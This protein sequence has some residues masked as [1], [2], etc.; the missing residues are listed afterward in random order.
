MVLDG[1]IRELDRIGNNAANEANDFSRRR[2]GNAVI[3]ARRDLSEDCGRWYPPVLHD[4]HRFFIAISR[5]LVNH[6][7]SD[8]TALDPFVWSAGALSKRRRLVHAVR[9]WAMLPRPPAIWDSEWINVPASAVSADDTAPVFWSN[10]WLFVR[11]PALGCWWFGSR[12]WWHLL[13]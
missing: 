3:D 11:C 6:G 4:L 9:D 12:S 13:C 7:G 10:V 8:G 5:A 1:R 2:V